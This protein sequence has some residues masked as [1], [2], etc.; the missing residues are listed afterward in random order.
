[1]I[2]VTRTVGAPAA[3]VWRLLVE[4]R[5]WPQWG[6]SVSAASVAGGI[7]RGGASGQV[8][9]LGAVWLSFRV[10]RFEPGRYWAWQVGGIPATG[11]RVAA[12]DARSC[13][14]SFDVPCWAAPYA[15]ICLA[16]IKRI[17]RMA[18]TLPPATHGAS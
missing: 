5:F 18:P 3:Q 6:P 12:L 10:T 11:H 15:L 2:R 14:L 1:M 13:K 9:V 8:Q 7:I 17:Q 4:T 16:A